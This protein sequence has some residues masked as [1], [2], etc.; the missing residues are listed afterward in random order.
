M[1]SLDR[2]PRLYG[3]GPGEGCRRQLIGLLQGYRAFSWAHEP[4]ACHRLR[5]DGVGEAEARH[6][7][8]L[9]T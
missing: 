7:R 9:L 5:E 8:H 4:G 1:E 3:Q 2:R 6:R